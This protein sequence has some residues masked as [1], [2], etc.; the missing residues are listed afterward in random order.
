MI[1]CQGLIFAPVPTL[2]GRKN[3]ARGKEAYMYK[4]FEIEHGNVEEKAL[5]SSYKVGE[6][7]LPAIT[8]G[9]TGRGREL[10]IL[11]VEYPDFNPKTSFNYLKFA[12]VEKLSSGKFR[13]VKADKQ[14]DDSKA[15]IVFRTPIGFRG[16]NEHTGDRNPAGFYCSSCKKEW[17]E[18][19]PEEG[20][21][22]PGCPQCG[23]ATFLKRK[24]LP[25]PGEILVKGKIAQGDA[26][27]MG[28]GQQ[29]VALV[30]KDVV[31]RTNLSG[32]L[33]GKP[34]AFYYIF[35]GQKILAATWDERQA[36]GL[37]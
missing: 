7:E 11:A 4:V 12:R 21:R 36:F 22:Y 24:F 25:F 37:F 33:Y 3:R 10:G 20:D 35:N 28:S 34:S 6:F 31:F 14:E 32:R 8:V 30:P 18:L 26:G 19:K 13:L 16:S 23:L 27:R 9:E 5:V 17:G 29:I 2:T 15:I 1:S